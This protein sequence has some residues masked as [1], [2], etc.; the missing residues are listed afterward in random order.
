MSGNIKRLQKVCV[1]QDLVDSVDSCNLQCRL[2]TLS[3]HITLLF[4]R[5][6]F[7]IGR[8]I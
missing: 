7:S 6:I 2:T 5:T 8:I 1:A 4:V 3:T